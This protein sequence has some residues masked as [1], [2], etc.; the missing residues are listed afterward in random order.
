MA[1]GSTSGADRGRE[2]F[3]QQHDIHH[4]G[5]CDQHGHDHQPQQNRGEAAGVHQQKH[6]V[7]QQRQA[8]SRS[9][10]QRTTTEAIA[11]TADQRVE[12]GVEH[13]GN[14]AQPQGGRFAQANRLGQVGVGVG[15]EVVQR[16][17]E[18]GGESERDDKGALLGRARYLL[19]RIGRTLMLQRFIDWRITEFAADVHGHTGHDD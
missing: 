5:N 7:G 10:Y 4:G 17:A 3:N 18:Q 2:Y 6:R 15:D 9:Q 12:Q 11:Q 13:Q 1:N 8:R 19:Q 14:T 16:D